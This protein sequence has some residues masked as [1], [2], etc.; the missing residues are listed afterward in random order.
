MLF[1][2]RKKPKGDYSAATYRRRFYKRRIQSINRHQ[3]YKAWANMRSRAGG[4]YA[5]YEASYTAKGI[6]VCDRWLN[7]FDNFLEDMG[8]CP[9]GL[10]LDRYP[11]NDGDYEP[12]NFRWATPAQQNRNLSSNKL[13][14]FQ[15]REMCFADACKIAGLHPATVKS[16][17]LNGMTLEKALALTPAPR[18]KPAALDLGTAWMLSLPS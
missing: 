15:G 16:R 2:F 14:I 3:A 12:D 10:S 6:K 5:Q 8:E 4:K 17:T 7:S 18:R 13:V 1:F 11:D 9:K